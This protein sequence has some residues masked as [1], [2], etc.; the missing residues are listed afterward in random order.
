MKSG[1]SVKKSRI[2]I[3]VLTYSNSAFGCNDCGEVVFINSRIV[4]K[5]GLAEGM[6]VD[7]LCIPNFDDKR[8]IA[9]WRVMRVDLFEHLA[10]APV[11][12]L[13]N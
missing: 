13:Y 2:C 5:M 9:P 6:V 10:D 12:R 7:G 8:H 1:L 11:E 4:E 3:E